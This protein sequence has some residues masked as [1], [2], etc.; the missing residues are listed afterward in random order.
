MRAARCTSIKQPE[1]DCCGVLR[2]NLK[3]RCCVPPV[4]QSYNIQNVMVRK[5]NKNKHTCTHACSLN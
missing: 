1:V 3:R 5:S 2:S 4:R